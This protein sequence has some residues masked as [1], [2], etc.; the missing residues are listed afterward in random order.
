MNAVQMPPR[1]EAKGAFLHV[2]PTSQR[3]VQGIS[4]PV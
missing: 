2:I 3:M 4:T 1:P